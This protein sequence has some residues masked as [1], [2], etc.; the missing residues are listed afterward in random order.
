MTR[1]L[2]D[3]IEITTGDTIDYS[4]IWLHG[5]GASGHDFEP[6]VPELKLLQRPGVRFIFPHAP[7]RPITINGGASMRGWYDITSLDFDQREQDI[8]GTEE[9]ALAVRDLIDDQIAQGVPAENIILAGFSQGGAVALYTALTHPQTLGG[10]LALSTYLPLHD[11]VRASL[12]AANA[13]IPILMAH[14]SADDVINIR[15]AEA[16]RVVLEDMGLNVEWH[17]YPIA[18]SVSLDEIEEV[19]RWLK[20]LF[21]M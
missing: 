7:V 4:V 15:H 21:G 12:S 11:H 19:S 9:S 5:L 2:L 3:K 13:K 17:A 10:I 16:S 8:A 6:V 20:R 1:K 18:H 14:G